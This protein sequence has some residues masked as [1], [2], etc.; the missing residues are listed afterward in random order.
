[1]TMV[2]DI[3]YELIKESE[4]LKKDLNIVNENRYFWS[5]IYRRGLELFFENW[6]LLKIPDSPDDKAHVIDVGEEGRWDLI[7]YKYYR[8]VKLWWF[9]CLAN[10]IRNPLFILPA[11]SAIKIPDIES[12]VKLD[13]SYLDG[14]R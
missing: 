12:L 13:K 5:K 11:G 8:T 3:T 10:K 9:I 1:M 7:S 2:K 4:D 14:V 6:D